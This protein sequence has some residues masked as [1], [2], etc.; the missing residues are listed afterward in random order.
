MKLLEQINDYI[1]FNEQ[2][3]KDKELII[4][5]LSEPDTIRLHI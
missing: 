1:P 3:E 2:E 5:W 4:K